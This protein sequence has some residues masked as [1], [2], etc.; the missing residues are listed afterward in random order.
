[1]AAK[2]PTH[3]ERAASLDLPAPHI[4]ILR[5]HL[6]S[7]LAGI[8]DDLNTP[9]RL[10]S[11]DRV[12]REAQAYE[13]LLVGLTTGQIVLPDEPARAAIETA[14]AAHDKESNYAEVAAN[15]DA[16]RDLFTALS[17]GAG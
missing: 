5:D 8:R 4:S 10:D 7:W 1:M 13:R 12:R 14:M 3:G 11:P 2:N 17:V 9:E 15:H 6:T 16:L